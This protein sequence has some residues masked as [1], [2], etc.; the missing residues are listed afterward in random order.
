VTASVSSTKVSLAGAMIPTTSSCYVKVDVIS[1]ISGVYTNTIP[2]NG[3][4]TSENITNANPTSDVLTVSI[5][6]TI[7]KQF[8]PVAIPPNGTS[9][10]TI[11]LNNSNTSPINLTSDFDDLLPTTP[12]NIYI[13]GTAH[14]STT[15]IGT[16]TAN[17]GATFVRFNSAGGSIPAGGCIINVDVTG[18]TAGSY[19]NT[20]AA[21]ALKTSVGNNPSPA[22][23][24]LLIST[25]GYISGR[26]FQDN[27]NIPNGT[28]ESGT[29]TPLANV[30]INLRDNSNAIIATTT[31]DAL[32]NYAFTG[33]TSGTYSVE[34]PTQPPGTGNGFTTAGTIVG[35]GSQG[36]ATN[37]AT[38][39]SRISNINLGINAGQV[40]G[41][42]NNNFAE[43]VGNRTLSGRVFLD[44]DNNG[45]INGTDQGIGGITINLTGTDVN[46]NTITHST[47]TAA[48]GSYSFTGL[49]AG[50]YIVTEPTQPAGTNNGITSAGTTG[51]NATVVTTTPSAIS[52]IPLLGADTISS[53]NNFAEIPGA[54][55]D[56][57]ISKTHSPSSFA[58][59]GSSGYYT[60]VPSN[61][62]SAV[63]SGAMTIVD[64]LPTGMTIA[65][66]ATGAGWTCIGSVGAAVVSCTSTTSIPAGG[67]GNAI[68][69]RVLVATG[70]SGQVLTNH[71]VI[72]GGGE[73]VGFNGNNTADDPTPIATGASIQGH[74]WL[75]KDH[76]R[77]L[78][79]GDIKQ[80]GW[81]VELLLNN[82][83]VATAITATNG[84]DAGFY[85]FTG[86]A[87]GSGYQ[88]RFRNPTTGLIYGNAVP[89]ETGG[90]Y[91]SGSSSINNP[92]G[93]QTTSGSLNYITLTSGQ[94]IT[95][96]SL[97]IDPAGVVYDAVTRNPVAGA[98]I[99]ISGPVGFNPSTDL[100]GGSPT[101]T[102]GVDGSYQFLLNPGSP[103]GIY[104]LAVTT[105]P[106]GYATLPSTLIP[107]CTATLSVAA[108]PPVFALVQSS[109]LAPAIGTTAHV[110]ASCPGT[111][112]GLNAGNQATTQYYFNFNFVAGSSNVI[113][114]H[115][116]L[117]P[118]TGGSVVVTK[119]TP[120]VNVAKGDLV[121][122]TITVRNNV[123]SIIS[124]QDRIPPGFK[125]RTGS[126]TINGVT[127]EPTVAGRDLIWTNQAFTSGQLKTYKLMLIVG[128]GVGE[129][130]YINQA[131]ALTGLNGNLLSNIAV[132]T[133][134][135]TP[136]PT[137]DCS[138]IIGKVFDDK[139]ANGYQDEG[140]PGIP[141]VRVVTV[142]GL[143]VTTD[144]E[145][146]FHIA[147][148]DIP[149]A[150][151]GSNFVMKLDERT[152]PSGY[153][154]TTENPRD[155]RL[156]QGKMAKLNF[157]ATVHRVVRLDINGDAFASG[158]MD[159]LPEWEK[160]LSALADRL[161]SRPSILR[162]AYNPGTDDPTLCKERL[163]AVSKKMNQLWKDKQK[164]GGAN[165]PLYPL[166]IEIVVEAQQ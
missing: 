140:E 139:N 3:L 124:V 95:Q 78:S 40:G 135:V 147:C 129:G 160:A 125:Y 152:L 166:V 93:A 10:L 127:M 107:V 116:P 123:A 60:I 16:V 30:L 156:T 72:S 110:P 149:Q 29:D 82:V 46:S 121:P 84:A 146:R 83:L 50:T 36:T 122:Y 25:Q 87:P 126:S 33:I 111:S 145:G 9:T 67:T 52:A 128:T 154:L 109:P 20:I 92:G 43:V 91:T 150:D 62:G 32:G 58:D 57:T 48:D 54:S 22:T 31:T 134:R 89:N 99:T 114:N 61:I 15:C 101:Q 102:T 11:V 120:L 59:G 66:P 118:I 97:P 1:N 7:G 151:H 34:E 115:I 65:A 63:T 80:N 37:L 68:T 133:V 81:I 55:P 45:Q 153:R 131:W 19:L 27:N 5:P 8:S 18:A 137:F 157:G 13:A 23:A 130:E 158:K 164:G 161:S 12:G 28:Y 98:V 64:T 117:D 21:G 155:V 106:S 4:T 42:I 26:V 85:S 51:G 56:L 76:D 88:V 163:E 77:T 69:L 39:P 144:S 24:T 17:P 53:N 47:T 119:T 113:N 2:E 162:I 136:D 14:M 70:T 100:V 79:P 49:P 44:Y 148:A 132:A 105:Y 90:A 6:P 108:A 41:S 96:Q 86:L 143:L 103:T 112:A 142:R 35:N 74:V 75:D 165:A 73:Q 94:T 71:A 104:T 138:D 159:L 38:T 141:N